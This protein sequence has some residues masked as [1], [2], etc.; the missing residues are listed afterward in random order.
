MAMVP[1]RN[2]DLWIAWLDKLTARAKFRI[3]NA[4][5]SKMKKGEYFMA[6]MKLQSFFHVRKK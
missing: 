5:S 2:I 3:G 6:K 1:R 4:T